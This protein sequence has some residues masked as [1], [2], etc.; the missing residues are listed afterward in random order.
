MFLSFHEL[1]SLLPVSAVFAQLAPRTSF[2]Y[3]KGNVYDESMVK[4]H[5]PALLQVVHVSKSAERSVRSQHG[6]L[7]NLVGFETGLNE[8]G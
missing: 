2:T 7:A 6:F 8:P 5:T 1:A 4:G 3:F